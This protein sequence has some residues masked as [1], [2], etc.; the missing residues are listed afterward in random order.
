MMKRQYKQWSEGEVPAEVKVAMGVLAAKKAADEAAAKMA[1]LMHPK[2]PG[3]QKLFTDAGHAIYERAS[4]AGSGRLA[5]AMGGVAL[6]TVGAFAAQR[7]LRA[8]P[9]VPEPD[10]TDLLVEEPTLE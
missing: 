3:K 4:N 7:R 2:A 10:A 9:T 5:A 1:A 8:R 6:L